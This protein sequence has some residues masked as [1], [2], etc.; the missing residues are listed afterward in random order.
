MALPIEL[1]ERPEHFRKFLTSVSFLVHEKNAYKK[2]L[3]KI[4]TL[5]LRKAF[6]DFANDVENGG[7]LYLAKVLLSGHSTSF[8][9]V[10]YVNNTI[11]PFYQVQ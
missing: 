2:I 5:A 1:P 8:F 4:K 7:T 11:L 3:E 6:K 9:K 10:M